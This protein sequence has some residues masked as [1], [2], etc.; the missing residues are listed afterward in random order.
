MNNTY[1]VVRAIRGPIVL[2]GVGVLFAID[3]AGPYGVDRTWPILLILIG[4]LKLAEQAALRATSPVAP[5][6]A[7]PRESRP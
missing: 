4:I 3:H 6:P 7:F 1:A 5:E 2:I